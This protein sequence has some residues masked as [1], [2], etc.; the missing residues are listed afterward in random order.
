MAEQHEDGRPG[1]E[2]ARIE[3]R[4]EAWRSYE[5]FE[6]AFARVEDAGARPMTPIQ[7]MKHLDAIVESVGEHLRY[8]TAGALY[9]ARLRGV[10]DVPIDPELMA[11]WVL[12]WT[13][14]PGTHGQGS[15][16]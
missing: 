11:H 13:R 3:G 7:A 8:A 9:V 2:Q 16:A 14:L 15:T 5:A 10:L 1:F 12:K 4:L 6:G